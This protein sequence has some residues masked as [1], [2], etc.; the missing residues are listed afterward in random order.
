MSCF[1]RRVDDVCEFPEKNGQEKVKAQVWQMAI[2]NVMM[3]M[4]MNGKILIN[5][6][7]TA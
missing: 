5:C 3:S 1:Y 4:L 6:C 2:N 7:L